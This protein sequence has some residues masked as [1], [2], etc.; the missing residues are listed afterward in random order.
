M[1]DLS[2]DDKNRHAIVAGILTDAIT[3]Y[4]LS[5]E[6]PF[7]GAWPVTFPVTVHPLIQ[8][9]EAELNGDSNHSIRLPS[10]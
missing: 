8:L 5:E 10:N 7:A 3:R 4:L 9:F 6:D 1:S 2:S